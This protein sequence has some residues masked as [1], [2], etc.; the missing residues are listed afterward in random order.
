MP[1]AEIHEIDKAIGS[2][3][4]E[5]QEN[6]AKA[7]ADLAKA[8]DKKEKVAATLVEAKEAV[9]AATKVRDP[10][11]QREMTLLATGQPSQELTNG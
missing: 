3:L 4:G 8:L 10:L 7:D 5:V 9:L 11:R 2:E 6:L 1:D